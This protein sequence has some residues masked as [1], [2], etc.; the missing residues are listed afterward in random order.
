MAWEEN[1]HVYLRVAGP[2]ALGPIVTVSNKM[3]AQVSLARKGDHILLVFRKQPQ[4]F[5][6][7]ML[8]EYQLV[9][10]LKIQAVNS[11]RVDPAPPDDDQLYPVVSVLE[12]RVVVAWED[13]RPGHTII[14]AN[15][16]LPGKSCAFEPPVRISEKPPVQRSVQYGTGHGV[17]RVAL[18]NYGDR[19]LFAAWADK[20]DFRE[21]YDI[22]GADKQDGNAFGANVRV[23]DDFGGNYR[24]WHSTMAGHRDGHL[25][26]VWTDERD[27]NMDIWFSWLEDGEWSEDLALPGASGP[28][29]QYHPSITMDADGNI[30]AAWIERDVVGGP[31]RILYTYGALEQ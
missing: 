22:Y 26:A 11:C 7:I 27:G 17:A 31:T 6:R 28:G 14:M 2:E 24:Q 18:A 9:D 3:S 4:R 1:E 15:Q 19:G 10:R 21:G 8:H 23:Q 5:G 12:N 30:H 13:R 16:S 20:R 25:I 29:V